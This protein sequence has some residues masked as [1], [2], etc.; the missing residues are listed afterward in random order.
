M[1]K[2]SLLWLGLFGLPLAAQ[3]Q[4]SGD[5]VYGDQTDVMTES[6]GVPNIQLILDNS[7]SMVQGE[8][9][10]ESVGYTVD[11][12]FVTCN[13]EC[14]LPGS[15][16]DG[17]TWP[18]YRP[19]LHNEY[20][21][22]SLSLAPHYCYSMEPRY[23]GGRSLVTDLVNEDWSHWPSRMTSSDSVSRAQQLVW[24]LTGCRQGA[25]DS[26]LERWASRANIAIQTLPNKAL[27]DDRSW[28][29]PLQYERL[30]FGARANSGQELNS[31]MNREYQPKN[32]TSLASAM[33]LAGVQMQ[34]QLGGLPSAECSEDNIIL[35]TDGQPLSGW[36]FRADGRDLGG[37]DERRLPP[38]QRLQYRDANQGPRFY[39][40]DGLGV[41][42]LATALREL[43]RPIR[44]SII[45]FGLT[46]PALI[47]NMETAAA[48]GGGTYHGASDF[49]QLYTAFDTILGNVVRNARTSFAS[50]SPSSERFFSGNDLY[51]NTFQPVSGGGVWDGT[52]GKYC[53]DPRKHCQ[54]TNNE[55]NCQSACLFLESNGRLV[56]NS[57][58]Q[59]FFTRNATVAMGGT[60]YRLTDRAV[61]LGPNPAPS[62]VAQSR[63]IFSWSGGGYER[64]LDRDGLVNLDVTGGAQ[65]VCEKQI[66]ANRL[67]GF[68]SASNSDS[69]SIRDRE[70]ATTNYPRPSDPAWAQGDTAH[71]STL[72]LSYRAR[73]SEGRDRPAR[74]VV[75]SNS[76][77]GL[78]HFFDEDGVEIGAL[79][80]AD[81]WVTGRDGVT[82]TDYLH[83]YEGSQESKRNFGFDG[84]MRLY[85]E[86]G[87]Q[88]A[89]KQGYVS[90]DGYINPGENAYLI[91]GLGR[92]GYAY[93]RLDVSE[94]GEDDALLTT[95]RNP[96]ASLTRDQGVYRE[97]RETWSAPW[98]GA[99][100]V[101]DNRVQRIA[102]FPSGH[103]RQAD[104]YRQ[105]D[106]A[107]AE[108]PDGPRDEGFPIWPLRRQETTNRDYPMTAAE[109][110]SQTSLWRHV[111]AQ[112]LNSSGAVRI[113]RFNPQHPDGVESGL[114]VARQC[115]DVPALSV[116]LALNCDANN[117]VVPAATAAAM[118]WPYLQGN[119]PTGA[120]WPCPS[121]GQNS[122]TDSIWRQLE[123]QDTL[124][125]AV[126]DNQCTMPEHL[127]MQRDAREFLR[128]QRTYTLV[129][130]RLHGDTPNTPLL[131]ADSDVQGGRPMAAYRVNFASFDVASPYELVLLGRDT[132]ARPGLRV[133]AAGMTDWVYGST[134]RIQLRI[135]SDATEAEL[136]QARIPSW[137]I[138]AIDTRYEV[139]EAVTHEP[140]LF[141]VDFD[142]WNGETVR[143]FSPVTAPDKAERQ[144]AARGL[145]FT[146]ECPRNEGSS[147]YTCVDST[148][149]G[150][151]GQGS[152][153]GFGDLEYL[154]CPISAEPAVY[155]EG[156]V[157]RAAYVGDECGQIWVLERKAN[158]ELSEVGAWKVRRLINLNDR[159]VMGMRVSPASKNFRKIFSRL[160]L[161]VSTCSGHR[162]VGVYF[163]TGNTQLPKR[164]ANRQEGYLG[165]GVTGEDKV[166][167]DVNGSEGGRDVV[168]LVWDHLWSE[169]D[170]RATT[171][172]PV[173]DRL[174][175]VTGS[176]LELAGDV[177]ERHR[178]WYMQLGPSEKALREPVVFDGAAFW[179]TYR[180]GMPSLN[181]CQ[182][183]QG[184]TVT[185]KM[186]ACTGRALP[187]REGNSSSQTNPT[188]PSNG[189]EADRRVVSVQTGEIGGGISVF[190]PANRPPI[191][192]N[193]PAPGSVEAENAST[194]GVLAQGAN[195]RKLQILL[196]RTSLSE[197]R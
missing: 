186:N 30:A 117:P 19:D 77:D 118:A 13:Q 62:R 79:Q 106:P 181:V 87:R 162:A 96:I 158:K 115:S 91:F 35:L 105:V 88:G 18:A 92:G 101:A 143:N 163:N 192:A 171:P 196:W 48:N 146:R 74:T 22:V 95:D 179:N 37:A 40:D 197:E 150:T 10:Y 45:G 85:H 122:Q 100:R 64:L 69:C 1:V 93:Y 3:A 108:R 172:S 47:N 46:N 16:A 165:A 59:D 94:L 114:A 102:V 68:R 116:D 17:Q 55:A 130:P 169:P 38:D 195:A 145:R 2:R 54:D 136:R 81:L 121:L 120:Q 112:A 151:G 98:V 27:N 6:T 28:Q 141:V 50:G 70:E 4:S 20:D 159:D 189:P 75:V 180:P 173:I 166:N 26:L 84:K 36:G 144:A 39:R 157:F 153:Q 131:P 111:D 21:E 113:D 9:P 128:G 134:V 127:A 31:F 123:H 139:E 34:D 42:Q 176:D 51:I 175:D 14:T 104:R 161:T 72:V 25:G 33:Y 124:R 99:V 23:L 7:A 125:S 107:L 97:L 78:L 52:I 53:V 60:G 190:T 149:G 140:S 89:G 154:R 167:G 80:I 152:S 41:R 156:G 109:I 155:T 194:N 83:L 5:I 177:A 135:R 137:S 129:P 15:T 193:L 49:S 110:S 170:P 12:Q 103:E 44:T 57:R 133:E 63:R 90:S 119:P 8:T 58:P 86:D 147:R 61:Q 142:R 191:V 160:E 73:E 183:N 184:Q 164:R 71:G 43:E 132:G 76:N 188:T 82:R 66:L 138:A 185:Y 187:E 178:G 67:Y 168:G 24:L 174:H 65:S 11:G 56:T 29:P 182:S 148:T 126:H 32:Y